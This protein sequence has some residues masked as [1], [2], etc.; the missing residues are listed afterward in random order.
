MLCYLC[1]FTN[2]QFTTFLHTY[3]YCYSVSSNLGTS[4]AFKLHLISL[5]YSQCVR[6]LFLVYSLCLIT[7]KA[8]QPRTPQMGV[9]QQFS[10]SFGAPKKP[11]PQVFTRT[12]DSPTPTRLKKRLAG[13]NESWVAEINRLY[14][15]EGTW[16]SEWECSKLVITLLILCKL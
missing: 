12:E 8:A 6:W 7:S 16:I 14:I 9:A 2:I 10:P 5:K 1:K 3:N 15:T 11:R 13:Q 4:F